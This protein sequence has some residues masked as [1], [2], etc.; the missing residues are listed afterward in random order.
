MQDLEYAHVKALLE[1]WWL[2][3][4]DAGHYKKTASC[5]VSAAWVKCDTLDCGWEVKA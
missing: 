3:A 1:L 2:H 5:K 4:A